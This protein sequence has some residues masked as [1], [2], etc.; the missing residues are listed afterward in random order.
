[1]FVRYVDT[2]TDKYLSDNVGRCSRESNCSYHYKPKEFFADNPQFSKTD[3]WKESDEYKKKLTPSVSKFPQAV[4]FVDCDIFTKSLKRYD[5]N[6][7]VQFLLGK[8]GTETTTQLI[9]RYYIGTSSHW[10]GKGATVF[11]QVNADDTIR[12]GKIILYNSGTGKRVKEPYNHINWVHSVLKLGDFNL[13]QCLFGEHLLKAEPMKPVAI[14]ES[15]KTAIIASVY[16]P[17]FIWLAVGSLANFK[18]DVC[19]VIRGR[20]VVLFPDLN[21]FDKWTTRAKELS[22][23]AHFTVSD[24]LET[25]ATEAERKDGLDIA[26]YLLRFDVKEFQD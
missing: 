16:L 20:K 14:V 3:N 1:M 25:K 24:L 17:Q 13:K 19:E 21:G 9:E 6:N 4:S 23:I 5:A 15:E 10:K 2:E 18:L 26:D 8:F 7:F 12:T 22:K 11:W